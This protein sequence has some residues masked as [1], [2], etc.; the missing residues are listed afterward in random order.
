MSTLRK[1]LGLGRPQAKAKS[2]PPA[3]PKP[4]APVEADRRLVVTHSCGCKIGVVYLQGSACPACAGKRRRERQHNRGV[5]CHERAMTAKRL[6]DSATFAATYDALAQRW[7]GTLT[8]GGRVF[9]AEASG[10]F[11]LMA[12][13]DQL[14]RTHSSGDQPS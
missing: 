12:D 9:E 6:P 7:V 13:L 4:A 11:R 14:Y 8:D 1:Q 2:P 3:K 10:V 5:A